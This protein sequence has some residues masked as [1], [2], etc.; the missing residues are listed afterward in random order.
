MLPAPSNAFVFFGATGDLAYKQVFPALLALTRDGQLDMPVIGISKSDWSCDQLVARARDSIETHG[1]MDSEAFAKLAARL[2]YISGDY[3]D[4]A[5]FTRL[6]TV[7]GNAD[8][9]PLHYLAIPPEM[10]GTVV[11]GL[12]GSGCAE[13]ARII[14]EKPFGRDLASARAL[15]RTLLEF[16]PDKA[17]FRID[18][19]LG[20]EPVQ[21][22]L[23]FRFAN[24]F[25][26]PIWN[27]IYIDSVQITMAEAFGIKGRGSF[28]ESAGAIRDVVQNHLLQVVSLLAMDAPA[29]QRSDAMRDAKHKLFKAM[30]PLSPDDVVRGQFA[31]YRKEPG[32]S[33]SSEVETFVALRL[34]ID[35]D[36]WTGVPFY[37]RAGKQMPGTATEVTV[38]L[39]PPSHAL[40]EPAPPNAVRFRISPDVFISI[41]AQVKTPG[42]AMIGETVE[43]VAQ[44]HE[45]GVETP[46]DRLLGE[47]LVG[48]ASL[49][50]RYDSIEAAW[51]TV[52]PVLGNT[53]PIQ[54]YEPQSWGPVKAAS[55]TAGDG[56]WHDPLFGETATAT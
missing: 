43:L 45:R 17:V 46:Y 56:G 12:S 23:Y 5:T 47:A 3:G 8:V 29:D 16:F 1:V 54:P 25:L 2:Q 21:N 55:L 35:N 37:I 31:G 32:V 19:Y 36:R 11:K 9:R 49:F 53:V 6:R 51:R 48:D 38:R 26:E 7:L 52:E 44:R 33:A 28:Y 40:F 22:L 39:K 20:K 14:V 10:F 24:S 42:E 15:N 13:G 27:R 30:R 4:N 41:D 18:H 50:A 34:H